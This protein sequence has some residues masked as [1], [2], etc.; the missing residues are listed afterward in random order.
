MAFFGGACRLW[1]SL[2]FVFVRV[3]VG[4]LLW[5]DTPLGATVFPVPSRAARSARSNFCREYVSICFVETSHGRSRGGS[6]W[7]MRAFVEYVFH[8]MHTANKAR[9]SRGGFVL[10][11]RPKGVVRICG[12]LYYSF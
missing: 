8:S 11:V 9:C 3:Q 2:M 4:L 5:R 6:R 10:P 12:R 7:S 1:T